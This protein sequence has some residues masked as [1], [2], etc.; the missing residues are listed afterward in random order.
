MIIASAIKITKPDGTEMIITGKRHHNCFETIHDMGIRR[1]F[2]EE[3]GFVTG[4]GSFLDRYQA[5]HYALLHKQI[6]K[7]EFPNV[8]Y[9][10]D[11]W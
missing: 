1:P 6:E 9:S 11:L 4:L 7:T 10:E 2:K 3:Q 5:C 8:L